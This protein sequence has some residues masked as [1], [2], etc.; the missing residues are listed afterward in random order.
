MPKD[1]NVE[2]DDPVKLQEAFD[3]AVEEPQAEPKPGEA[4]YDWSQ[5]YDTETLYTHTFPD[6][7][8][9]A[10]KPFTA[11]F[12]K[13]WLYKIRSLKTNVDVELAAIDR[14]SC[15]EART[16]LENLPDG[17]G[18]PIDELWSAWSTSD[19]KTAD[20]GLSSKN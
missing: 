10:L 1:K 14:G 2:M 5:H 3:P 9:V 4:G 11:I 15:P 20:E 16:V 18:D 8:V 17:E 13:T 7:T 12:S 19:T 6:G